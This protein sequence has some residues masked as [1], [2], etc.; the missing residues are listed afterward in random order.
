MQNDRTETTKRQSVHEEIQN[1]YK[2]M[3]NIYQ[4]RLHRQ[5]TTLD[6]LCVLSTK[7]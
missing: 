5:E 6:D 3:Q 7:M 4:E 2:E 1:D